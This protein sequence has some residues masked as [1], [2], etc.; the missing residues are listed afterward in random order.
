MGFGVLSWWFRAWDL[1]NIESR[2]GLPSLM[3]GVQGLDVWG[4]GPRR[5]VRG[6][7]LVVQGLGLGQHREPLGPPYGK[8]RLGHPRAEGSGSRV[9]G[10][11][12][13]V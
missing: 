11:E 7:E 2:L 6:L 12:F 1:G 10:W 5:R 4:S 9:G 13:G 3:F 8:S